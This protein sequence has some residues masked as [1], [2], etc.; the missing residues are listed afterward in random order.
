MQPNIEKNKYSLGGEVMRFKL[1]AIALCSSFLMVVPL[2][3]EE[4]GM[5]GLWDRIG[6]FSLS[7][8]QTEYQR[9]LLAG[10]EIYD[11]PN[12]WC[13]GYNVMRHAYST[14]TAVQIEEYEDR[15]VLRYEGNAS[16]RDIPL[17]G[18]TPSTNT[19]I[20]GSSTATRDRSGAIVIDTVGFPDALA[21]GT[22]IM[23]SDSLKMRERFQLSADGET[24]EVLLMAMD[25]KAYE[26]PRVSSHT[27]TRTPNPDYFFP[28]ECVLYED[29]Q[30]FSPEIEAERRN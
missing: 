13:E 18:K 6:N 7:P 2:Y 23:T 30:F 22:N 4:G 15:I 21:H 29:E 10:H 19:G 24:I 17:D 11:D 5:T 1:G 25:E 8:G 12:V 14:N 9:N 20:I 26:W 27:Y 28:S 16:V 3:A